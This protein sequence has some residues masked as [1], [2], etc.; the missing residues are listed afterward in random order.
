M[1]EFSSIGKQTSR[2]FTDLYRTSQQNSPDVNA[3]VKTANDI[4]YSKKVASMQARHGIQKVGFAEVS[5]KNTRDMEKKLNED[6]KD[7]LAPS[8]RF[9]GIVAGLGAVSGGAI[10]IKNNLQEQREEEELQKQQAELRNLRLKLDQETEQDNNELTSLIEKAQEVRRQKLESSEQ[11]TQNSTSLQ[12]GSENSGVSADPGPA[13]QPSG[14]DVD[15]QEVY[16]YLTKSK[17]LSHNHAYGIMAN[18]DRESSFRVNPAGGD[19]GNSFGMLQWNN[20]YGRSQLMKK[21]VP[22]WQTNWRGQLDHA[23][24]QNQLPEYNAVINEFLNTDWQTPQAASEHFLRKWER[25]LHVENDIRKNNQFIA[26][27]NYAN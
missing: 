22:D 4:E 15:R 13:I 24:S 9:A 23:L 25:P 16:D 7:I 26:G 12:T 8:Q 2:N 18:I 14:G 5:K 19:G 3:L 27:Y 17:G 20:T 21:N 11:G 10:M 1:A 6:V